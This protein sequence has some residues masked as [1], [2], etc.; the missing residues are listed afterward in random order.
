MNCFGVEGSVLV[1]D[2]DAGQLEAACRAYRRCSMITLTN[3]TACR[4]HAAVQAVSTATEGA[5]TEQ[6]QSACEQAHDECIANPEPIVQQYQ[7][8]EQ[9]LAEAPCGMPIDCSASFEQLTECA[10]GYA[11]VALLAYPA[12]SELTTS[13]ELGRIPEPEACAALP[14]DCTDLLVLPAQ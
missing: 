1:S 4:L 7:Q 8:G 14:G 12:C 13:T 11:S 5:T 9:Q 2:L 6:L 10:E 3:D